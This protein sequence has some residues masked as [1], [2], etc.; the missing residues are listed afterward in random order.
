MSGR[1]GGL[2]AWGMFAAL[3]AVCAFL[4]IPSE[5]RKTAKN[6]KADYVQT[7]EA[8]AM[9][10]IVCDVN[11]RRQTGALYLCGYALAVESVSSKAHSDSIQATSK[12]RQEVS[13]TVLLC[14]RDASL[15]RGYVADIRNLRD[16]RSFA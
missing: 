1:F 6:L 3:I 16:N 2:G 12:R 15:R 8:F 5:H 11:V 4:S 7:V 9:P 10:L 14:Y 13:A